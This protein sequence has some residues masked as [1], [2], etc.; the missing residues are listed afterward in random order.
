MSRSVS[1]NK[2][3]DQFKVTEV[4]LVYR[5]R[6]KPE[7]RP[8]IRDPESAYKILL[9]SWNMNR[10]ELVEEFKILLMDRAHTC[11]GVSSISSGGMSYC[12]V[13]P[14]IIFATALKARASSI[15]LAHNHPSGNLKPSDADIALTRKLQEGGKLLEISVPDHLI[16]TPYRFYSMTENGPF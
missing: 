16:I 6:Q 5:N 1:Q 10:I 8:K 15:I 14:K 7:D 13:D 2:L 9:A 3:I 4:E 12:I 11:L